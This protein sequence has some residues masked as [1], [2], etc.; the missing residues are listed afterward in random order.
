MAPDLWTGF[1]FFGIPLTVGLLGFIHASRLFYRVYGPRGGLVS[2]QQPVELPDGTDER[3]RPS[4]WR[5]VQY[6]LLLVGSALLVAHSAR[7]LAR[8]YGFL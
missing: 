5:L 7:W 3:E 2:G 6:A 8:I 4:Q 1:V